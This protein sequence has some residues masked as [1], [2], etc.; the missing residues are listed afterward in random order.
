MSHPGL[1]P[2][3]RCHDTKALIDFLVKAFGF[4]EHFVVP[5]G[6]GIIHAEVRWPGGGGV[7]LGDA[8]TG[9]DDHDSLV[10]S[11]RPNRCVRK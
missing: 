2:T 1:F 11:C 6:N 10:L 7:M 8:V 5:E 3:I 4:I 9:N